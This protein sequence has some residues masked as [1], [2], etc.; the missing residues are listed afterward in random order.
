VQSLPS[1]K[2]PP[3]LPVPRIAR[4]FPGSWP[5][6]RCRSRCALD[7]LLSSEADA[8]LPP[9]VRPSSEKLSKYFLFVVVEERSPAF[10]CLFRTFPI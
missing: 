2:K 10:P 7:L 1:F 3:A 8:S 6:L 5:P 4:W 9:K